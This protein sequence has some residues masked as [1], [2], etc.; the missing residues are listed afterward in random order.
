MKKLLLIFIPLFAVLACTNSRIADTHFQGKIVYQIKGNN[1]LDS[2][3]Q[4]DYQIVYAKDSMLRIENNTLIGKQVYIKH[5]PRNRAYIL[6]DVGGAK[7]AIQTI[8]DTVKE[9]SNYTYKSIKK[10]Q[11]INQYS[12]YQV[13]VKDHEM[14]TVLTMNYYP[15]ISAKYGTAYTEMPG[16]P[17]RYYLFADNHWI[18]YEITTIEEKEIDIDL[19]GIPSDH[20]IIT[21]DKFIEMLQEQEEY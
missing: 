1:F 14:D 5:I 18:K 12:T 11:D 16:L 10:K 21:F 20:Q 8:P 7:L 2:S 13:E 3:E 19:F 17:F 15:N 6:M 4:V 9:V